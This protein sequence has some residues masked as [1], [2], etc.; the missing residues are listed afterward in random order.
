MLKTRSNCGPPG[1]VSAATSAGMPST[2]VASTPRRCSA[3]STLRPES[4][5]TSRSDDVPPSST[6]TRPNWAGSWMSSGEVMS[7][8]LAGDRRRQ[9]ARQFIGDGADVTG[10]H[11][12][13]HVAVTHDAGQGIRQFVERLEQH[14]LHATPRADRATERFAVRAGDR[15]FAGR[16]HL[17]DDERV[18]IRQHLRE[19]VE[20][21][22]RARVA[23][24][25]EDQHDTT[26]R[27]ALARGLDG[28]RDL[29]RMMAVVVHDRDLADAGVD[30]GDPLQAPLDA[31]EA[32]QRALDG[33]IVDSRVRSRR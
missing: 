11:R 28:R 7:V 32:G 29:G 23:M 4:S 22:A 15:G 13:H 25:L 24:R 12:Q 26:V 2:A 27:P 19:L 20:Q 16:I 14:G 21:V 3:S 9:G 18:G 1:A 10:A 33:G 8:G 6:A 31:L 17:G 5:D 30:V